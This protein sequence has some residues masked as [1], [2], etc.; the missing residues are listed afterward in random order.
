MSL[1]DMLSE[2]QGDPWPVMQARRPLRATG[3]ALSVAVGLLEVPATY[4]CVSNVYDSLFVVMYTFLCVSVHV[5]EYGCTHHAIH[6]RSVHARPGNDHQRRTEE[7][8]SIASRH[9]EGQRPPPQ[10]SLESN[11]H[12]PEINM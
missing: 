6:G 5:S 8:D 9:R 1:T 2:L 3:V 4:S 12:D 7:R 10:E 11:Q